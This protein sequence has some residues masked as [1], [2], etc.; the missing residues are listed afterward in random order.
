MT[1]KSLLRASMKVRNQPL[2]VDLPAHVLPA[3]AG[4]WK[5]LAKRKGLTVKFWHATPSPESPNNPYAVS[6]KIED[7]LP[8]ITPKTRLLAFTGCSNIL[9]TI[10]PVKDI[11]AAARTKA[12]ELGVRKLEV[13][14]DC[15]AYAPHRRIDVRAWD[16][17][18]CFFSLYKVRPPYFLNLHHHLHYPSP[19]PILPSGKGLSS[20]LNVLPQVYGPHIGAL[21]TRAASLEGSLASL[22]HHFLPVENKS[23]KLQPGGPGYELV[24]G[25]T[26]VPPYLRSLS[27]SG[28]L[29]DAFAK[30][31]EHEQTLVKPLLGYL[32][33]KEARGVRIVGEEGSG[34]NRAPTIS[35]VVGGERP[36]RSRDV[37]KVFDAQ[38]NVSLLTQLCAVTSCSTD[39][40]QIGIRFGHFYAY[41]LV[42][43]LAP[44]LDLDDAVVRISLVHYNTVEQVLH[45][46][47]IL[48][49]VLA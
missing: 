18:Y 32:K 43:G 3:N 11:T 45:I 6:L 22:A 46:I 33:S 13:C 14:I 24:Y 15:V 34:L 12:H 25:C 27:P 7:L 44:K 41:T 9:G 40:C 19:I 48:E 20:S 1:K 10:V 37:V 28:S 21:Y 47:G 17:D 4:P 16:V 8:L 30:I 29:E 5:K 23:Y 42:E 36:I 38:K 26:A 49:E 31:A 39:L 2:R 35:F